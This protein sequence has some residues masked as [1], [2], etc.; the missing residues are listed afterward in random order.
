VKAPKQEE[1]GWP[2][3]IWSGEADQDVEPTR[4]SQMP[5]WIEILSQ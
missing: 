4:R 1:R 3:E 2:I 5:I